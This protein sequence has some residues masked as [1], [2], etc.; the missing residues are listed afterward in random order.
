MKNMKFLLAIALF[1]GIT[2]MNAQKKMQKQKQLQTQIQTP[3]PTDK[4]PQLKAFRSLL[5][6]AK[7]AADKGNL[8][9][10]KKSSEKLISLAN[11]LNINNLPASFK[12]QKLIDD[13]EQLKSQSVLLR[14]AVV[15]NMEVKDI[16]SALTQLNVIYK[17]LEG[18]CNVKK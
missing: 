6:E 7:Q 12:S 1:F 14:E 11:D 13:M 17:S 16:L 3:S 10:I 8:E 4:W 5:N 9:P 15:G 18:E 2:V